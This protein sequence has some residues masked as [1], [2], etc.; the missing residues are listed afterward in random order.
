[1]DIEERLRTLEVAHAALAIDHLALANVCEA[2]LPLIS[3]DPS[4]IRRQLLKAYDMA[5]HTM[6]HLGYDADLQRDVRER[7]D[8]LSESILGAADSGDTTGQWPGSSQ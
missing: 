8:D 2:L 3:C 6:E 5:T 1:M 7:I 4:A